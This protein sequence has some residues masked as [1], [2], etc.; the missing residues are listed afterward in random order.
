MRPSS[1]WDSLRRALSKYP[2]P[3]TKITVYRGHKGKKV[4]KTTVLADPFSGDVM[5]VTDKLE[6]AELYAKSHDGYITEFVLEGR[7]ID[8][9]DLLMKLDGEYQED[10]DSSVMLEFCDA[11]NI[12]WGEIEDADE[13]VVFDLSKLKEVRTW[14]YVKP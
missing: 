4:T 11:I 13:I 3:V 2:A 14:K 6:L 1:H 12:G 10:I 8:A 9:E 7:L 5:F